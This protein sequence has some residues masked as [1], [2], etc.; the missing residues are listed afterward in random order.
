[1]KP[2][3][4]Q[5]MSIKV[6]IV[7]DDAAF[8]ENLRSYIGG[9]P[10]FE[11]LGGFPSAEAALEAIPTLKPNV[12]L[13]DINLPG[14]SGIQCV[15]KLKTKQPELLIMMLTVYENSKRIFEALSAG[16][17]GYLLKTTE[18]EE[19]LA[20]IRELSNGGAP[21]SS[22]IARKVVQAFLPADP[23]EPLV[24][25]LAPRE[26]EV[27]NLLSQGCAYKQIAAQM[28]VSDSTIRTYIGRIYH[29]LHVNCRTQAV[30]KYLDAAGTGPRRPWF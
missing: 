25:Q 1:M 19:L 23:Q 16:A 2:Q 5:V 8:L 21:M 6:C 18:P 27:L 14:M 4:K 20:A 15:K 10:G 7:E 3:N 24:E 9:S 30:V 29:K 11:C 17:C 13:M 12:V 22:H 26:S 28:N